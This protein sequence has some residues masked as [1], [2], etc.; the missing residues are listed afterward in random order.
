MNPSDELIPYE[1]DQL[2]RV[3]LEF[4]EAMDSSDLRYLSC[5]LV[6]KLQL[7]DEHLLDRAI[8]RAMDACISLS[9]P[10][11]KHFRR[12]FIIKENGIHRGWR[13]SALGCYL[14]IVNEDPVH[15]LVAQFQAFLF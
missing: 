8:E 9:V 11:R 5:D 1:L 7:S 10:S 15:P 6:E 3:I 2:P 4:V 14:T 12:V 13:M